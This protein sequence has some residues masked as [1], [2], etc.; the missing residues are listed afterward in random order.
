MTTLLEHVANGYMFFGKGE[1]RLFIYSEIS[2]VES[3][4]LTGY[5]TVWVA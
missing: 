4:S 1:C 5:A 3:G 2:A